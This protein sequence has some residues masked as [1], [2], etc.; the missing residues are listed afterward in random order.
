MA[1]CHRHRGIARGIERGVHTAAYTRAFLTGKKRVTLWIRGVVKGGGKRK[2]LVM[3]PETNV[4]PPCCP[5]ALHTSWQVA[6]VQLKERDGVRKGLQMC[7]T[8]VS[9]PNLHVPGPGTKPEDGTDHNGCARALA[10]GPAL[11]TRRCL[12]G[13]MALGLQG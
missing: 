10:L 8:S 7:P 2:G 11:L 12:G 4:H 9:F 6:S 5:S 3:L 1:T 13:C